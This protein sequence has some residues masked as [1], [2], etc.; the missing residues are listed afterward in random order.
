MLLHGN[1]MQQ[2]NVQFHRSGVFVAATNTLGKHLLIGEAIVFTL[3]SVIIWELL[4]N[5][6]KNIAFWMWINAYQY[7]HKATSINKPI[8]R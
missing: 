5:M 4:Q 2:C 8:C 7:T 6:P 1:C 3:F